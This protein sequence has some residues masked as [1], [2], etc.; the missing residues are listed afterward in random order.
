[1]SVSMSLFGK[2]MGH[3]TVDT[4]RLIFSP[5]EFEA[6]F[7][8]AIARNPWDRLLSAFLFMK[9]GGRT[10]TDR[11]W[12][13]R[14]LGAYGDFDSFVKG[15]VKRENIRKYIHF[16]PQA[17]FICGMNSSPAVDFI[18]R[19][20]NLEEDYAAISRRLG[21]QN[22]LIHLNASRP[23]RKDY[24]QYYT[25]ETAAIVSEIYAQDIQ[26]LGYSL[27]IAAVSFV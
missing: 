17:D 7:K 25:N 20:E 11:E 22:K 16:R 26:L 1:M 10:D 2:F 15:W 21:L 19:F 23:G 18:G 6:Y 12:A 3:R 13:A 9:S 14:N 8:F 5:D 4:Y 24:R 27:T